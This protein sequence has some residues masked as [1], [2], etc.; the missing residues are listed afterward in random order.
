M[1]ERPDNWESLRAL[2]LGLTLPGVAEATAWD[3]AHPQ[4]GPS[5]R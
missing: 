5:T 4:N 1:P 3:E 2:G